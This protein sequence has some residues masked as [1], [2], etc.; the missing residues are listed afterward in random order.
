MA[1][2]IMSRVILLTS[3]NGIEE[4]CSLGRL[5]DVSVNEQ[6]V[7]LGVDVLHHDLETIEASGLGD[8]N[9]AAESLDQILVDDTIGGSEEGEDVGDEVLLILVESVVP[10]VE[11]LGQVDFLGSP[12]RR[13]GLLVHLPDLFTVNVSL[14]SR[15]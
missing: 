13:L 12:E 4:V 3:I 5:L 8:L 9:L 15:W 7:C 1:G 10:V 6:R 2:A 11:I 14:K